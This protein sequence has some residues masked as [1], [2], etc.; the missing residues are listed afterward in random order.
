[1]AQVL[2]LSRNNIER[3]IGLVRQQAVQVADSATQ[4]TVT[5]NEVAEANEAAT[6][7]ASR[8]Q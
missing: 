5:A 2:E 8:K 7:R 1:M 6:A 3:D 4:I